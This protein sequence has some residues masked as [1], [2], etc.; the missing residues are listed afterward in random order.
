MRR[1]QQIGI[2]IIGTD[3]LVGKLNFIRSLQVGFK[4][5]DPEITLNPY[6]T[7]GIT[8][9]NL[10]KTIWINCFT[11]RYRLAANRLGIPKPYSI[12][13]RQFANLMRRNKLQA[14]EKATQHLSLRRLGHWPAPGFAGHYSLAINEHVAGA[15]DLSPVDRAPLERILEATP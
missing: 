9:G 3:A 12:V 10:T 5:L 6:Q 13:I 15:Y 2:A 4:R 7:Q 1:G 14:R 11:N 8:Q